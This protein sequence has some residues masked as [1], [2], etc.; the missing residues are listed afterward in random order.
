MKRFW[1]KVNKTPGQGPD[2]MCWE[3]TASRRGNR[4]GQFGFRGKVAYAHRMAW[5]LVRGD[6]PNGL[7]VLH[8]CDNP[9]CCRPDHLFLGT[10]ADNMVDRDSK[11][12]QAAGEKIKQ[13]KLTKD[14]V[15]TIRQIYQHGVLAQ[16]QL[17]DKFGVCRS[18][19]SRIVN[20]KKW[21]HVQ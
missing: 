19:I 17:A 7:C 4:Y 21:Q 16:Y 5:T 13:A 6:I 10:Q 8:H 3:W 2:G 15:N 11:G 9:L 12:R 20:H 18:H 1:D 14:D